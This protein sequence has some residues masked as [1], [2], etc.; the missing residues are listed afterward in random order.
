MLPNPLFLVLLSVIFCQ[1]AGGS[2]INLLDKCFILSYLKLKYFKIFLIDKHLII[3][4]LHES[5]LFYV[6]RMGILHFSLNEISHKSL[7]LF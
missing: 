1:V 6:K 7:N 4:W 2:K 5:Y 3:K